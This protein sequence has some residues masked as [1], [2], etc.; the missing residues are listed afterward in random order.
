MDMVKELITGYGYIAIYGLLAL[1]IIGLPVPDEIMMTFVGYL[2]SIS[3]LNLEEALLVSFLGSI[4]G[5]VVSYFVGKKVGK[6]FLRKYGKWL[7][8]TPERLNRLEAWFNKYGSWTLVVAYFIP[9]IRHL[10]S[11][12]SGMNGMRSGKYMLFASAGAICWC[13]V[14]LLLGY[15]FGVLT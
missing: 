7:R 3:V 10:A 1:G 4:T 11:Y 13:F 12:L 9:G 15:F 14:F 6:P 2:T 5:M 8:M